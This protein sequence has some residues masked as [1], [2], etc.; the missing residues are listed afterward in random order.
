MT[1]IKLVNVL[2]QEG[3]RTTIKDVSLD[4]KES[5]RIGIKISGEESEILFDLIEGKEMPSSGEIEREIQLILSEKS[6][7]G[8]Y[9]SMTVHSYLK[10]YKK[11]AAFEK[12]LEEYIA[13]FSLSDVW[14]TKIKKLT[15]EQR[16]RVSLFRLFLFSPQLILL[17]DPLNNLTDEGIELYLK[18]IEHLRA[19]QIATLITSNYVE[20]LLLLSSEIY[21]YNHSTGLEKTDLV[22]ESDIISQ[23]KVEHGTIQPKNVFKVTCKLAE[24]TIFFSP[25]EIDFIESINSVSNIRIGDEYFPTDLTMNQ[26]EEKLITFGFFRC[27]RSYLVNLQR[28]SELISYSKN[29]YTLILKGNPHAKLPLSRNRLEEMKSLITF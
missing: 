28:V 24:K 4:V 14:Q 18:A 23:E 10:F 15:K 2:K 22:E 6:D 7:D 8:L 29:S 25:D 16:K 3:N 11:I 19:N 17:E 5:S 27:H 20:D 12:P 13:T 9:E 26:L 1:L 21:R